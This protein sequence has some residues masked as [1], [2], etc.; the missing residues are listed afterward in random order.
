MMQMANMLPVARVVKS[1]G[2]DGRV[3]LRM[4]SAT[5]MVLKRE[6]P[7][8]IFFDELP[9]PFF[10]DE[11]APK[12]NNGFLVKFGGIETFEDSEEINGSIVYTS[13]SKKVSKGKTSD[14]IEF[15]V[16]YA[17]KD[18]K[19]LF[20][21]KISAF[22]DFPGNPCIGVTS[23]I[24]GSEEKLIPFAEEFIVDINNRKREIIV[25]VPQ[26]LFEI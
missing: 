19:G 10:I 11:I 12:G 4:T 5:K 3:I 1:F 9:V 14:Q 23:D 16:G 13:T 26:G 18:S 17:L 6:E 2:D 22:Y 21:G 8:F 24:E 7:V 15:I 20:C 25:D